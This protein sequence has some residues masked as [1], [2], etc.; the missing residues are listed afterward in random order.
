MRWTVPVVTS[1]QT[2]HHVGA[3]T[4][5]LNYW[6]GACAGCG[7]IFKISTDSHRLTWDGEA[8]VLGAGPPIWP[9]HNWIEPRLDLPER[10]P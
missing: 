9:G 8:F 4:I 6:I 5:G 2:L 10:R 1:D 7:S 3:I